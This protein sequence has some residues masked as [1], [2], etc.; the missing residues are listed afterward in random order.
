MLSQK[1]TYTIE[2]INDNN[3]K[4]RINTCKVLLVASYSY[5]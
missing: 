5:S 3:K 2:K 4:Q 1:H